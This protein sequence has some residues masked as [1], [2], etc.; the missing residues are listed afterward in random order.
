MVMIS[1]RVS[2][3][4]QEKHKVT[5]EEV[6]Q[7]IAN[8]DQ[9]SNKLFEDTREEHKT[10]PPTLWFISETDHGRKLKIV[11]LP[12]D[13]NFHLKTAYQANSDEL[14]LYKRLCQNK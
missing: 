2:L 14:A 13:G 11:I 3:K 12:Q 8:L 4:I 9:T 5:E 1:T 10:T 6:A 7:C